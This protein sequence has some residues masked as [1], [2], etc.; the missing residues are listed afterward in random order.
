MNSFH[1]HDIIQ[2]RAA[3]IAVSPSTVRGKGSKGTVSAARRY[4]RKMKLGDFQVRTQAAFLAALDGHTEALQ[5]KLPKPV[6]RWGLARKVMNIF[7]RDCVYSR[8][9]CA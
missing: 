3:R 2:S 6:R 7:L 8:H 5:Q 9:L 1:L 4:L